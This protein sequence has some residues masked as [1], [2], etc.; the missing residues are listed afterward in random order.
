MR[1]KSEAMSFV[2][3]EV[4]IELTSDHFEAADHRRIFR[5]AVE[6]AISEAAKEPVGVVVDSDHYHIY[7]ESSN[8]LFMWVLPTELKQCLYHWDTQDTLDACTFAIL[9]PISHFQSETEKT[10][11]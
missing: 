1:N 2:V 7:D 8:L 11:Q 5:N 3:S 4:T 10:K 9:L 6:I